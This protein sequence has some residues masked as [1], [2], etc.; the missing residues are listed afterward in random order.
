MTWVTVAVA[1]ASLIG[2]AMGANASRKAGNQ[3]AAAAGAASQAQLQAG[4][5][6]NQLQRQMF[7]QNQV[8]QSPYLQAGQSAQAAIMQG[9]GLG[10]L[11][12][13]PGSPDPREYKPGSTPGGTYTNSDGAPVDERGNPIQNTAGQ[14][15]RNYGAT[16]ADLDRASSSVEQGQFTKGYAPADLQMDPSYAWRLSQ[17]R[18]TLEA[19]AAARGGLLSGQ[20]GADLVNYGQ[21]AAAQEYGAAF[22]RNRTTQTDMYNRLA[23]L[24]GIG[25]QTGANMGAA[26]AAYGQQVGANTIGAAGASSNYLTSGAQAQ[27]QAGVNSAAAR[28]QGIQQGLG[29]WASLQYLNG[30]PGTFATDRSSFR[31]DDPYRNPGYVGGGEGE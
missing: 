3:Q 17:G 12:A 1:G 4:R 5:E 11:R 8:T 24:A 13:A 19:G 9:L 22:D 7:E 30:R 26:G 14:L 10:Q 27:A 2:S 18:K 6:A 16:Q 25:Q 28:N 21:N 23:A 29:N 31:M 20:T 15:A